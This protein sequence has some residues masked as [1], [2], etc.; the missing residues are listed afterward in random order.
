MHA[1]KFRS[2]GFQHL[3]LLPYLALPERMVRSVVEWTLLD[4]KC[5][6]GFVRS[7]IVALRGFVECGREKDLG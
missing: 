1:A 2:L 5:L 6:K 3:S 4:V 7:S